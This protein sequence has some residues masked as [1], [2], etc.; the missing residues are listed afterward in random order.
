MSAGKIAWVLGGGSG[1]GAATGRRFGAAGHAVVLVGLDPA[2][3]AATADAICADGGRCWWR[4]LDVADDDAADRLFAEIAVRHG[5]LDVLVNA[6]AQVGPPTFAPAIAQ[7]REHF[8]RILA[9]N[10]GAA[11]FLSQ[12]AARVMRGQ[13]GGAIVNVSSVGG[14]AAQENAAAYCISKAGLDQMTRSLALEWAP[15]GI[16][17]NAVAPGPI[18]VGRS[19]GGAA[20][21]ASGATMQFVRRTLLGRH[22]RPAEIA[23]VILFLA[24]PAASFVTGEVV[25]ADGG[26][27]AY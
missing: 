3:L 6:A 23:E 16:R 2:G 27:L 15:H 25:R 8:D 11:F 17:V 9:V 13:G 21:R 20:R 26:F 10:L 4:S 14:S 1:I 12:R 22:G 5:R 7:R 19:D 24:S 18:D